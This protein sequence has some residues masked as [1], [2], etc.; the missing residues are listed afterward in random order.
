MPRTGCLALGDLACYCRHCRGLTDRARDTDGLLP[1]GLG[2]FAGL[3]AS[4][5]AMYRH[6]AGAG[7]AA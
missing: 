3:V 4:Q 1:S 6:A 2:T 7:D 5:C